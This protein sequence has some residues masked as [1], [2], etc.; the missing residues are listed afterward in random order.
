[1]TDDAA[2]GAVLT[3][4]PVDAYHLEKAIEVDGV[5]AGLRTT[6]ND[7][8][9]ALYAFTARKRGLG[10]PVQSAAAHVHG[11]SLAVADATGREDF[12]G[13]VQGEPFLLAS[14]DGSLMHMFAAG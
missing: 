2:G 8:D 6:R 14:F 3:L 11:G 13:K 10:A 7:L 12:Y 9:V 1:V 4:V 5:S